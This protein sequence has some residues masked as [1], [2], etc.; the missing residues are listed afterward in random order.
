MRHFSCHL[1]KL[2]VRYDRKDLAEA[3]RVAGLYIGY[4][5]KLDW[6]SVGR[7]PVTSPSMSRPALSQ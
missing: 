3:A 7:S 2:L 6:R 1:S 4:W 5:F